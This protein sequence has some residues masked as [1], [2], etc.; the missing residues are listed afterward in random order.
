VLLLYQA[1]RPP[2]LASEPVFDRVLAAWEPGGA[3][4]GSARQ[5]PP[6][7]SPER[8]TETE[9]KTRSQPETKTRAETKTKAEK[10]KKARAVSGESPR[11]G[12][13]GSA[14]RK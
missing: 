13:P 5:L 11:Q 4:E 8:K 9:T 6:A 2:A 12:L 10:V 1:V 14:R 3:E 7:V